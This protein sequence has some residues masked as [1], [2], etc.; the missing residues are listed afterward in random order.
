MIPATAGLDWQ[1]PRPELPRVAAIVNWF[2]I[3]DVVDLLDGPKSEGL[4]RHLA[5]DRDAIA[6]RGSPLTYVRADLPPVLTIHGDA[7]P[8]VTYT[9]AT[10]LHDAL[11][12]AGVSSEIV[13]IPKGLHGSFPR[14]QQLRA[15]AAVR[16]FLTR[17]RLLPSSNAPTPQ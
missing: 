1:C 17:H 16:A 12:K 15:F 11:T 6:R 10:R 13:T 2:G 5:G 9:H 3:T 7:D 8:T 4:C 14:E